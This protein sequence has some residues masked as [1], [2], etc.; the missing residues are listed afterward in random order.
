M[1][2]VTRSPLRSSL[3]IACVI[4]CLGAPGLS[5]A[6]TT[7]FTLK[8]LSTGKCLHSNDAGNVFPWTCDSKNRY[9]KWEFTSEDGMFGV[10]QNVQTTLFLDFASG[11]TK[12]SARRYSGTASAPKWFL[13]PWSGGDIGLHH[14]NTG[15]CIYNTPATSYVG[16]S[17]ETTRVSCGYF[18][19]SRWKVI[20]SP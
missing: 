5:S 20:L 6:A 9:Q 17:V 15:Y 3:L 4:A 7:I 2:K 11:T 8:N 10:L 14:M 18:L 19:S 12:P 13:L 1:N 16:Q